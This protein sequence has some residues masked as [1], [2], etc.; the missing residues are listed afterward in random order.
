MRLL[1]F[2]PVATL[3]ALWV[4]AGILP[5]ASVLA[6]WGAGWWLAATIP[7][8]R[9]KAKATAVLGGVL[10]LGIAVLG[11]TS[12]PFV[13]IAAGYAVAVGLGLAADSS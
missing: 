12:D 5:G 4:A 2:A 1:L 9:G 13:A 8:Q 10:P 11:T 7:P 3:F 6:L